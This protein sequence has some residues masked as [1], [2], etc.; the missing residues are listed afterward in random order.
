MSQRTL[1]F[2][3]TEMCSYDCAIR[4]FQYLANPP[5][6]KPFTRFGDISYALAWF[7]TT[8]S[9]EKL[10]FKRCLK[11]WGRDQGG[12]LRCHVDHLRVEP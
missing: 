4:T 7:F 5:N 6:I 9:I 8:I 12:W 10:Q 1:S 11:V 3:H 2:R